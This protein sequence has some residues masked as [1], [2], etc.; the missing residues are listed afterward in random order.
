MP[1][2]LPRAAGV[3]TVPHDWQ[4]T[5]AAVCSLPHRA[6]LDTDERSGHV[7]LRVVRTF[8]VTDSPGGL[9]SARKFAPLGGKV[10]EFAVICP[11]FPCITHS[12]LLHVDPPRY[13]RACLP[14]S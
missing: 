13:S 9:S 4:S 11:L 10:Q 8:T 5:P 3:S 12:E 2:T 1:R 6:Q 7:N 14:H